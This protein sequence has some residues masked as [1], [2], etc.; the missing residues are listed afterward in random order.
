[1]HMVPQNN[2]IQMYVTICIM[3]LIKSSKEIFRNFAML[4][5][6]VWHVWT[7][8]CDCLKDDFYATASRSDMPF[9]QRY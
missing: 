4:L 5:Q 3:C 8:L 2:L 1:M 6:S 7:F 9:N